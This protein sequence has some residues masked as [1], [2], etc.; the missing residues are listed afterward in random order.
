MLSLSKHEVKKGA[1]RKPPL[2][3]FRLSDFLQP[4]AFMDFGSINAITTPPRM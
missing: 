3:S 4:I 2:L 1:A